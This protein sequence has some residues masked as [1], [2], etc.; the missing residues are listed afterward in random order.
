MDR[1]TAVLDEVRADVRARDT[2]TWLEKERILLESCHPRQRDF[3]IDTGRRICALVARGGGKTTGGRARFVRRMLKT[4]RARCLYVATTRQQAEE[5]MWAP[6]KDLVEKLGIEAHFNE[7]KLKC[8]FRRN[9]AWLRLVGAD[10]KREIEKHRGQPFH[11]VGI[12]EAASFPVQLL[13]HLMFRVIG[14]RLGDYGGVLW[15]I[16]TPGHVL[17]GPFYDST[18][19]GSP[20]ARKW[21]DR[22]QTPGWSRWSYHHWTL[23]DGAEAGIA[24]MRNLWAEALREKE[25]NDWSDEHPVWRR[26]YLGQWAADDT[27]RVY[28]YRPHL[29]DGT[30]WNQWD[31]ERTPQGFAILPEGH[32]WRYVYGMDMGHAD[33][34]ALEVFAYSETSKELYH[35]YEFERRG[36]YAKTIAEV[37]LGPDLDADHPSGVVGVTG[38]PDGM[39][40]DTAGLGDALLAELRDV[41]GVAVEPAVKKDKFDSIELFNGDL[42]DG[43]IKILR[44]SRLEEQLLHLQ[45]AINDVGQL[46]EDR[47]ARNDCADGAIYAR[48]CAL[49]HFAQDAPPP[50]PTPGSREAIQAEMDAFEEREEQAAGDFESVLLS[51]G[52]YHDEFFGD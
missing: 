49:H 36:M 5:L 19:P 37:L 32:T 45:W 18:R 24:A 4:P 43:R 33:P 44:G 50:P 23:Q 41:Y 11:E 40:A 15:L 2:S 9:G 27:E 17:A 8:T 39:V 10:D 35:V 3:V 1:L 21:E 31:P 48:R 46:K 28:K 14:P 38:W 29:D 30:P 20:I 6:L 34:F 52:E 16:G 26:E 42:L 47:T 12:D 51:E 7:T 13:D 22:E 25:A